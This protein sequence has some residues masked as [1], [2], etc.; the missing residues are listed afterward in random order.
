[1]SMIRE[2]FIELEGSI[3]KVLDN[4]VKNSANLPKEFYNVEQSKRAQENHLGMG[5]PG[6]MTE[7]NGEVNYTDIEKSYEKQY[8]HIKYSDGRKIERELLDDEEFAEVKKR[9]KS[10]AYG[11]VLTLNYRAVQWMNDGFSTFQSADRLSLFNA[12]HKITAT[13]SATQ[14]NTGTSDM[15]VATVEE[16]MTTMREFKDNNG[17][18]M[19]VQPR[20]II[21]GEHWRKTAKQIV[22]SDKEAFTADNQTNAFKDELTYFCTPFITGKKWAI[23]D[24][25]LMKDGT[26]LNWYMRRDPRKVEYQDDFDTEFGKY[27]VVGRWSYGADMWYFAH[28][29]NPS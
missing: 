12:A 1:M 5:A 9:A 8:R 24:P 23:V 15:T 4:Y 29:H 25:V 14:S 22:G 28:G 26:G 18:L 16:T 27:K 2:N 3:Q 17:N 7:W 20:L 6:L 11:V 21:C 19:M 10:L 13:D